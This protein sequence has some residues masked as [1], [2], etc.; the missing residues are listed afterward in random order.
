MLVCTVQ[1]PPQ[2]LSVSELAPAVSTV[3]LRSTLPELSTLTIIGGREP[4][5][6]PTVVDG[7]GVAVGVTTGVV[8]EGMVV[9]GL[10]EPTWVGGLGVTI[11]AIEDGKV[12]DEVEEE[13][14]YVVVCACVLA[15]SA[16]AKSTTA[17]L[18]A[19]RAVG[20]A[21]VVFVWFITRVFSGL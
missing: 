7:V 3:P 16:N 9:D 14:G 2:L 6:T 11:G 20:R 5:L 10:E 17:I 8:E 12:V 18:A 1:V 19:V 15:I 21:F 13:T 4:A